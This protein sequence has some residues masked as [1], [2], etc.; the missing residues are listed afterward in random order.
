MSNDNIGKDVGKGLKGI[1][2]MYGKGGM[3]DQLKTAGEKPTGPA[4]GDKTKGGK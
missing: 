1:K 3:I 2:D 4:S